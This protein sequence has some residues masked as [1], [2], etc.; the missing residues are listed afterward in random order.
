[1]SKSVLEGFSV[2]LLKTNAGKELAKMMM[3]SGMSG[4][5]L[6]GP[7]LDK[8]RCDYV[9][10]LKGDVLQLGPGTGR[11]IHYFP[12]NKINKVIAIDKFPNEKCLE[13][14]HNVGL[15]YQLL[16]GDL[17][18]Y[19]EF[20]QLQKQQFDCILMTLTGCLLKEPVATLSMARNFLKPG[21]RLIL[22]EHGYSKDD[23]DIQ[24]DQ[25][26]QE[27]SANWAEAA[28][29]CV[30]TNDWGNIVERAG[31]AI[32]KYEEREVDGLALFQNPLYCI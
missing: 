25:L 5:F 17:D 23:L 31:F 28:H 24:A 21:G 19:E 32:E 1:M 22:L 27:F 8:A 20:N 11:D 30:L 2:W 12:A 13:I 16:P 4:E 10:L 15:N 18:C 14:A 6:K 7:K 3:T 29:G 26:D 9:S